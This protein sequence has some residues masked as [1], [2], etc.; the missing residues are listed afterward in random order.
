MERLVADALF[1]FKLA[2]W[3]GDVRGFVNVGW[4]FYSQLSGRYPGEDIAC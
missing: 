3:P 2:Y 1:D 4:H